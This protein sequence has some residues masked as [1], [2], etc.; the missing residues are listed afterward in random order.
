[1][2][3]CF[4]SLFSTPFSERNKKKCNWLGLGRVR[5]RVCVACVCVRVKLFSSTF[6]GEIKCFSRNL[7]QFIRCQDNNGSPI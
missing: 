2:T 4:C 7:K 3:L 5:V 6:Y 1:M